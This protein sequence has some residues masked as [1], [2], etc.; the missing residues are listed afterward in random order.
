V[1][2]DAGF[3]TLFTEFGHELRNVGLPI[4]SDDVMAYCSAI[5]ELNP[6]DILDV[7]WAGRSTLVSKRDHIPLYDNVFRSFF[8]DEKSEFKSENRLKI[9]ASQARKLSST[10]CTRERHSRNSRRRAPHGAASF[11]FGTIPQ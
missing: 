9:K 10:S 3:I 2:D 6:S 8:L 7:Y 1:S 5:A 11:N 4:G